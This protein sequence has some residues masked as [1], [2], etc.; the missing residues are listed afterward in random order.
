MLNNQVNESPRNDAEFTLLPSTQTVE[1]I[2]KF[3]EQ[4]LPVFCT[5]YLSSQDFSH[6]EDEISKE[7][8]FFL[9]AE[10]KHTS[11]LIHFDA[12]KGVDF[13]IR[14]QPLKINAQAIFVIE[15]K[16]LTR[17]NKDYVQGRTG[18][19]ERFKREQVGFDQR[20][21]V[22]AML[23][24]V[25]KNNFAYWYHKINTWIETLIEQSDTNDDIR[26]EQQ[27]FLKEF[28]PSTP[29]IARYTSTHSRKTQKHIELHH[30]WLNMC[31]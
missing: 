6:Y 5:A 7:L 25:Q 9:N 27:D 12:Q 4:R 11:L 3:L 16:R 17:T 23:G 13:L 15:A 22:S 10:A 20:L 29:Q 18:G 21:T 1:F 14:V 30:F 28:P 26:W 2:L 19:I 31:D 8:L 24:Y